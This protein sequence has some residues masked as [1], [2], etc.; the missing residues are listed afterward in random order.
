MVND[1]SVLPYFRLHEPWEVGACSEV[2]GKAMPDH[3][4]IVEL[5]LI[6]TMNA[7]QGNVARSRKVSRCGVLSLAAAHFA[8]PEHMAAVAPVAI[9]V[10]DLV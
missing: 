10:P 3:A 5:L 8:Q 9:D 4:A 7:V 2:G 6:N 1:I